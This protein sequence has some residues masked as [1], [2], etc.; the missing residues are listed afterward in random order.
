MK[1]KFSPSWKSSVQPRKQRKYRKHAPLHL[2]SAF[3]NVHLS[4]ELRTKYGKRS[5]GIRQGDKVRI[6][7]GRFVKTEGTVESVNL[8]K[9]KVYISKA[10]IQKKDGSKTK[11]PL[12]P[13]NLLLLEAV[14]DDKKRS[15]KLNKVKP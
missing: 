9:I 3:L 8:K 1:T 7:K 5:M 13:S 6:M 10:E 14:M 2:R 12:D 11:Y 15:K 4:K